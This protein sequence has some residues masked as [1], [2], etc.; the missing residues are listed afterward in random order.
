MVPVSLER[1]H[2]DEDCLLSFLAS[3]VM[4]Q[5]KPAFTVYRHTAISLSLSIQASPSAIAS[6][7][8]AVFA[9]LLI[10]FFLGGRPSTG[11]AAPDGLADASSK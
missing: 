3:S 8:L 1:Q 9:F 11:V 10:R 5:C 7:C 4:K 6:R 2:D